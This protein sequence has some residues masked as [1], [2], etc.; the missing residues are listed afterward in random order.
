MFILRDNQ[1]ERWSRFNL[2][3]AGEDSMSSWLPAEGGGGVEAHPLGQ[4]NRQT[5]DYELSQNTGILYTPGQLGWDDSAA[6]RLSEA[7]I[8]KLPG[9][10]SQKAVYGGGFHLGG[11]DPIQNY[12]DLYTTPYE[13]AAGQWKASKKA[14][15]YLGAKTD[16]SVMDEE[17]FK[18]AYVRR[19][20]SYLNN[21]QEGWWERNKGWVQGL[22][23]V[24]GVVAGGLISELAAAGAAAAPVAEAG[25]TTAMEIGAPAA[26]AG[27]GSTTAMEIGA[28]ATV[29]G[30]GGVGSTTAMQ[31]GAPAV[32][33][34]T[35]A[36]SGFGG[37]Q[38]AAANVSGAGV[39]TTE[40]GSEAAVGG[41]SGVNTAQKVGGSLLGSAGDAA[42]LA[43]VGGALYQILGMQ[44]EQP[45]PS[46]ES[47]AMEPVQAPTPVVPQVPQAAATNPPVKE[48][49]QQ[50]Y[51]TRRLAEMRRR[52]GYRATLLGGRYGGTPIDIFRPMLTPVRA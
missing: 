47:A 7:G 44:E 13:Q 30:L 5:L 1:L 25:G 12:I 9:W 19:G 36:L 39:P 28:P 46:I 20:F 40:A 15:Q 2:R 10:F 38:A 14:L 41:W 42:K 31:T 35:E 27:G 43:L 32:V 49:E 4:K 16:A 29:G 33:L 22:G 18:E 11:H 8:D 26:I 17:G 48:A 6:R 52:A 21:P 37:L 3:A 24:G 45:S 50:D 23:A 34:G 51:E